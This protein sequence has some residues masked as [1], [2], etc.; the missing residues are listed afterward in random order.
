MIFAGQVG[1]AQRTFTTSRA[2]A[3][4]GDELAEVM[5]L[6]TLAVLALECRRRS[7]QQSSKVQDVTDERGFRV[8]VIESAQQPC[9]SSAPGLHTAPSIGYGAGATRWSAWS[10]Q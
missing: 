4:T 8:Q 3:G 1:L 9:V 5:A 2:P 10:A 6:R 7:D